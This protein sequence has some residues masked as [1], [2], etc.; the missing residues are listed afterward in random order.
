[1]FKKTAVITFLVIVGAVSYFGFIKNLV[2]IPLE[3]Q[4]IDTMDIDVYLTNTKIS[5]KGI[6]EKVFP[7]KRQILKTDETE[8]MALHQLVQ[9]SNIGELGEGYDTAI[10]G[11]TKINSVTIQNGVAYADFDQWLE[12]GISESCQITAIKSQIETTLK[13]FEPIKNVIISINGKTF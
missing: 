13:Q 12:Y 7:I 11:K 5:P 10:N 6:C 9:G 8:F 2:S 1:M 3:L 4:N